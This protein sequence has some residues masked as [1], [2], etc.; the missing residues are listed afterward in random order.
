MPDR[1][2]RFEALAHEV[3][4]PLH[5]YAT[6]R[7]GREL[8]DDVV[9]DAFLA[10]WRRLDDV[11]DADPL[12]WCYGVARLCVNNTLRGE[13]RHLNLVARIKSLTPQPP[14]D[15]SPQTGY[16]AE[17]HEALARLSDG[18]REILR[19]W[20]WE[21]LTPSEIAVALDIT[22]NAA[23]IRLHRARQ[24]LAEELHV[25]PRKA[26]GTAGHKQVQERR[27]P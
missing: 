2:A 8:A 9:A 21:S 22:A 18:D 12:P 4:A 24:H 17:L 10:L 25:E 15:P 11:P 5:R 19:L 3:G 27:T 13:R 26:G 23:S 7:V 6:R 20:A 1:R 14:V 16:D